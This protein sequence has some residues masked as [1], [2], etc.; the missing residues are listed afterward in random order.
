MM[1]QQTSKTAVVAG[2]T[3]LVGRELVRQLLEQPSYCKVTV[4]VRRTTGLSHPK[5]SERQISFDRLEEEL[6]GE[7]NEGLLQGADVF[8]ALG[9][10]IKTAGSQEAFRRVDYEY[11]L[12]LGRA[13]RRGGAACYVIVSS[14]GADPQS[15]IF[16][17][18]VKGET[19]RD[20]TAL[21]LPR[22]VI[23]RPS[24]LLGDRQEKRPGERAAA[25]LFKPLGT[26]MIGPLAKYRAIEARTVAIAMRLAARE[27]GGPQVEVI[28]SGRMAS[29]VSAAGSCRS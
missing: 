20:L 12:A 29:L 19:E 2:A 27:A 16:Y 8:C 10:T 15:R 17:S 25:V 1:D 21:G 7:R 5:L 26:L 14:L 6:N 9:T 11:P 22:L 3:G 4:L 23:L 18:R 28:D 24:L 13:A